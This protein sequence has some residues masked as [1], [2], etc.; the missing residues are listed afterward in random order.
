MAVRILKPSNP[1]THAAIRELTMI[2]FRQPDPRR[3]FSRRAWVGGSGNRLVF[4]VRQ[5]RGRAGAPWIR[6]AAVAAA[7]LIS[8]IEPNLAA[9]QAAP[10]RFEVAS[11]RPWQLPPR[12]YVLAGGATSFVIQG[13]TVS[14]QS[15]LLG[16]I[17]AAYNVKP[18]Q[19]SVEPGWAK[20]DL[21]ELTAKSA[22]VPSVDQARQM[23]QALLAD[24]FS[25]Q[26][27]R[28]TKEVPVYNLVVTQEGSKLTPT[29]V[30]PTSPPTP[31]TFAGSLVRFNYVSRTLADLTDLLASH[32]DRPILDK[33]GLSGRYDFTLEF[34]RNNPD[35]TR[36]PGDTSVFN[37]ARKQLG[38][39]L[40]A[41]KEPV[42]IV[43]VDHAE[44]ASEN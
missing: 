22:G 20:V 14:A 32:V 16:L 29:S 19:V 43:V 4:D 24:R 23:L 17:C 28:D 44:K 25:L 15:S 37:A 3:G 11:I 42:P 27:H 35:T 9:A 34:E 26:I 40:V 39:A 2:Y 36:L 8:T 33:T 7:V 13:N 12:T 41:A 31:A 21:Y 5:S 1:S 18:F 10:L 38:L 6:G 30:D